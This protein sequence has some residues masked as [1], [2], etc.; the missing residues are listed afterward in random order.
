MLTHRPSVVGRRICVKASLVG[1]SRGRPSSVDAGPADVSRHES[2]R[3]PE[4]ELDRQLEERPQSVDDLLR[5]TGRS[6]SF[7]A[8]PVPNSA[9]RG[10]C[11]AA[12]TSFYQALA[13]CCSRTNPGHAGPLPPSTGVASV[14][15]SRACTMASGTVRVLKHR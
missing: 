11:K 4:H 5:V 13:R 1:P 2:V 15:E 9:S 3:L 6:H 10:W 7:S 14:A 8:R 12:T